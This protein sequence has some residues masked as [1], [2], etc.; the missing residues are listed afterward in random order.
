MFVDLSDNFRL[1][2]FFGGL[3]NGA[4]ADLI[5]IVFGTLDFPFHLQHFFP[6]HLQ[7][8]KTKTNSTSFEDFYGFLHDF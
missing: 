5:V 3:K 7:S 1:Q 8:T 6:I 4:F 2:E